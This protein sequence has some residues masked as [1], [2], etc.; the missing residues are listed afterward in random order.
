MT[1]ILGTPQGTPWSR[2]L[3]L[4][5]PVEVYKAFS[6]IVYYTAASNVVTQRSSQRSSPG[7]SVA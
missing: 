3:Q 1:F 7:R 6:P 5:R 2:A 4:G